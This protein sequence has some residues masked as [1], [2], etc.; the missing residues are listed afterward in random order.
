MIF[1]QNIR[2]AR[3]LNLL[4]VLL[5]ADTAERSSDEKNT[6]PSRKPQSIKQGIIIFCSVI[7]IEILCD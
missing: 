6:A 7:L 4:H 5:A 2:S 1:P 3:Q